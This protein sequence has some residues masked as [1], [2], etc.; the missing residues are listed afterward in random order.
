MTS[1]ARLAS[2]TE[3]SSKKVGDALGEAFRAGVHRSMKVLYVAVVICVVFMA[4][5]SLAIYTVLKNESRAATVAAVAKQQIDDNTNRIQVLESAVAALNQAR[6][7]AGQG[8]VLEF[9][10]TVGG[11]ERSC[12]LD[13]TSAPSTPSYTCK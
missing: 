10:Y 6:K 2:A 13:P 11:V 1:A 7:Q 3:E 8:P 4:V 12:K 9:T 5:Y